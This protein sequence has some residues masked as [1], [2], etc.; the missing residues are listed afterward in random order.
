ME[1]W[2]FEKYADLPAVLTEEGKKYSYREIDKLWKI[3]AV[4]INAR[5]LV[6]LFADND[7]GS[8]VGYLS[9]IQK[10]SIPILLP[11]PKE[12]VSIWQIV[13]AYQPQYLWM[14]ENEFNILKQGLMQYQEK[15]FFLDYVLLERKED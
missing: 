12:N 7:L 6:G 10:D 13:R 2:D 5:T 8:L 1:L 9:C 4:Q 3:L 15:F 14:G 11:T